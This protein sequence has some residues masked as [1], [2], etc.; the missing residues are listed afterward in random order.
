MW[1]TG[2]AYPW[3]VADDPGFVER[4]VEI[5]VDEVAI[6]ASYHST[7]AATPFQTSRTAVVAE[8]A[9]LYRPVRDQAWGGRNLRPAPGPWTDRTQDKVADAVSVVRDAG[10][11]TALWVVLTHNS[12]LG[13][14]HP[15]RSVRNCF[16]ENYAWALCPA[17]EDVREYAATLAAEAVRD[18]RPDTVILESCGQMGAVHQHMHE[19]TDA[20]WAPAVARLLSVCCCSA[21]TTAWRRAGLDPERITGMLR[22]QVRTIMATGDLGATADGLPEEIST[23]LLRTRQQH[24]DALRAAVLAE[25]GSAGRV[26]LH[27]SADPWAT[28]AL[29]GL[30]PFTSG[31]IDAVVLPGWQVGPGSLDAVRQ[32]RASVPDTVDVGSYVTAVAPMP[33]T[34]IQGYVRDLHAAGAGEL[35]L[36][37]LGLAGPARLPYLR[38]AVTAAH[39]PPCAPSVPF[40]ALLG[41]TNGRPTASIPYA[42]S[43]A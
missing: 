32:T 23:A 19:K 40:D 29:P 4:A 39:T 8:K 22:E 14:E 7:R 36:Y 38:D 28:G 42:R 21:C 24:T 3:D 35:H 25:V 37:H 10:L 15:D 31:D 20:V 43:L 6:A 26:I 11:R 2:Y 41:A 34:D 30:T 13:A 27:A 17:H 9:G 1:V 16:G 18:L 33:V 12:A 5:G